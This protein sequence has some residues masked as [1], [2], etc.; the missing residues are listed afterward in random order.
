APAGAGGP[1]LDMTAARY[2]LFDANGFKYS[3]RLHAE[4]RIHR[5]GQT[6]RCVYID[7]DSGT[8]IEERVFDALRKKGNALK[9]FRREVDR[10]KRQG[11]R[12]SVR[13]LIES[14]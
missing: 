9:L 7:L 13:K 2:M 10:V 12:G 4:D 8:G 14:L 1:G 6:R 11:I 3:A 5:I